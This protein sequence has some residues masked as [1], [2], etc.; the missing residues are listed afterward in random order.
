MSLR[1]TNNVIGTCALVG[2]FGVSL[3]AAQDSQPPSAVISSVSATVGSVD[4]EER[5]L[6]LMTGVGHALRTV[7]IRVPPASRITIAGTSGGL[8]ELRRGDVVR[9]GYRRTPEG[10]VATSIE[11]PQTTPRS[12]KR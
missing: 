2:A 5:M 4:T 7:W 9:V 1:R 11:T 3:S 6:K 10:N 8:A 12:E